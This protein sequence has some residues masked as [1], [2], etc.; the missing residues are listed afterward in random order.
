MSM[1]L[2]VPKGQERKVEVALDLYSELL[3]I[4]YKNP[5]TELFLIWGLKSSLEEKGCTYEKVED[6]KVSLIL[7][8]KGA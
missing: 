5:F 1:R 7:K 4:K 3:K 2:V 8:V 6:G